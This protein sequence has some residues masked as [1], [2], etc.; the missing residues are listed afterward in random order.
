MTTVKLKMRAIY[1]AFLSLIGF[2]L[3]AILGIAFLYFFYDKITTVESDI[4]V[5]GNLSV[6]YISGK[7][8]SV[9]DSLNMNFSVT[10]GGNEISYYN[11][12]FSKIR[13]NGNYKL[14]YNDV[15]IN[16]GELKT[17]DEITTDY[18]SIDI[19]ETKEYKL[20]IINT[21]D[22]NL[23]ATLN[24]IPH[25]SLNTTFADLILKNNS[26]SE[27]ALS[28]VGLEAAKENEGLIKGTDDIGVSY[29]FRGNINNNYVS[30]GNM[31]WRIVRINGDGT[32]RLVLDGV[33]DTISNYY[34]SNNFNRKYEESNINKY[35]KDWLQMNLSDVADNIANTRFCSDIVYNDEYTYQAYDRIITNNIP[36]LNCLGE[37][38]TSNIGLLS[39]DEIILAGA[40][41]TSF[42]R[43]YYLYNS[44][45][46]NPWYTMTAAKGDD[47][48]MN[49]FMI[50][51]S[52]NVVTNISGDLYRNVRPVINLVKNVEM[53]GSGTIEDPY[54]LK[55]NWD[56]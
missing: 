42:N 16:E 12:S 19:N 18:I 3:I 35:L 8:I 34:P 45:I 56:V 50:D 32:V 1:K 21:G 41:K 13:G 27:N 37:N 7:N 40:S 24:V 29:Y 39:I 14:Y 52:S 31:L 38:I 4:E 49:M 47:K 2:L 20:E 26:V 53:L 25:E 55:N 48:S 46:T 30:F 22:F 17:I 11:V 51:G 44:K 15:L 6:N 10:N 36:T 33:T 23:K 43:D 28:E 54:K 9:E 5:A